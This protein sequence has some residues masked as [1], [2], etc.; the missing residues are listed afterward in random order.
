MAP[1]RHS[2]PLRSSPAFKAKPCWKGWECGWLVYLVG[3]LDI[4]S[5]LSEVQLLFR[6]FAA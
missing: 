3:R 1:E 4:V 5:Q 2:P 6:R